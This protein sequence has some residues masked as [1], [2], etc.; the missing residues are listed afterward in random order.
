M[1]VV[2]EAEHVWHADIA[3]GK[4]PT[5]KESWKSTQ[6]IATVGHVL[7][8]PPDDH[9]LVFSRYRKAHQGEHAGLLA[10]GPD[11]RLPI[12]QFEATWWLAGHPLTAP[13]HEVVA[14][15]SIQAKK[16]KLLT[17]DITAGGL[18]K[19]QQRP[20]SVVLRLELQQ[21]VEHVDFVT[22]WH[23]RGEVSFLR[24]LCKRLP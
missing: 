4:P 19:T 9:Q 12:G 23:G 6:H 3:H 14:T 15:V 16:Q 1:V 20:F 18:A 24:T 8:A 7:P 5:S 22:W 21:F 13:D 17:H 2:V 10:V 11:A